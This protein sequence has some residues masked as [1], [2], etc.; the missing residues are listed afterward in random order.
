MDTAA[1]CITSRT[2]FGAWV[3]KLKKIVGKRY[4][5][6]IK[7]NLARL[8]RNRKRSTPRTN[9]GYTSQAK[10]LFRSVRAKLPPIITA[11]DRR[12]NFLSIVPPKKFSLTANY[13]ET[14][15][16]IYDFKSHF[17]I[18]GD[19]VCE[20][21]LKRRTYAEFG[22]IDEIGAGAGLV[23]AAE[24]HR[25]AQTRPG[26]INV[27]DDLWAENVRSYFLDTGL[28]DLLNIDP[29]SIGVKASD[30]PI[31][32]TLKF[33]SGR[34]SAGK[35][36][37]ALIEEIQGLAGQS[38]G[39]RA[40]V[41]NAIAEAL[42]NVKHAYPSW[43]RSWP[44]RS[45][46]RWWTSGFWE[47]SS[48]TV[49]LQLYDQGAGIPATLPRQTYYPRLLRRFEPERNDAGL[50]A[51]AMEY[52]RTSTGQKGRGKGLAEMTDW[53]ENSG[54]GFLKILSGAG[55]VTYRP[56][57]K[58]TRRNY[59]APFCGTLVQWELTLVD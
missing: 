44:Y 16:F 52:G 25:Y 30:D 21:G 7:A 8:R 53:I 34:T 31:R 2:L 26:Q 41:Y 47:P 36:A 56:G 18:R 45:S 27:H 24:I 33:A 54:S 11:I 40:T 9:S 32:Q 49:G 28:F 22:E 4:A 38:V 14:L 17:G 5:S 42:A 50:I 57:R 37:K 48:K 51:A 59:D 13:E 12:D 29:R 20:D 1:T 55:E 43:F 15:A 58:I 3:E 10:D 19:V 23:L 46:R 6:I 39:S 35:D